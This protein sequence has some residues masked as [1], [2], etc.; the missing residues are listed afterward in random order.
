M[1][2]TDSIP[3][4][5]I[6][7]SGRKVVIF[8]IELLRGQLLSPVYTNLDIVAGLVYRHTTVEPVVVQRVDDGKTLQVLA[9]NESIEELYQK[10]PSVEIW[11]GCSVHSGFDIATSEQMML[12]E[13]LQ[14]VARNENALGEG[15]SMW[16]SRPTPVPQCKNSCPV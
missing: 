6:R 4:I 9:E 15:V 16:I 1:L 12:E 7:E 8:T 11:L 3:P 2:L 10:L 14:Q 13:G 5:L